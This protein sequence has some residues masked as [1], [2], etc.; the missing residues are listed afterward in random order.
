MPK[1]CIHIH[2]GKK[3]PGNYAEYLEYD[4]KKQA[5]ENKSGKLWTEGGIAREERSAR[6]T[7]V[8][9]VHCMVW[10]GPNKRDMR[11]RN[12]R[13]FIPCLY[14]YYYSIAYKYDFDMMV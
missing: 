2:N 8:T 6:P 12:K 1:Q 9:G 7:N 5:K 3:E 10:H 4:D 11:A 14:T 13:M